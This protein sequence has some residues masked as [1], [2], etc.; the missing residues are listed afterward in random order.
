MSTEARHSPSPTVNCRRAPESE[1]QIIVCSITRYL[2]VSHMQTHHAGALTGHAEIVL[3]GP[4][5]QRCDG[6]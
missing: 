6:C 1:G 3:K 5:H 4:P 2:V